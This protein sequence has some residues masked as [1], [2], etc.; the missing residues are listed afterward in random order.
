[1][2]RDGAAASAAN[3]LPPNADATPMLPAWRKKVLRPVESTGLSI[4]F[5]MAPLPDLQALPG[6]IATRRYASTSTIAVQ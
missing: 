1:M 3:V 6:G 4:F 5:F 2:M